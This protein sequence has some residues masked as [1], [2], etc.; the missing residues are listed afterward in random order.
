MRTAI[1]MSGTSPVS[2]RMRQRSDPAAVASVQD[3][4]VNACS[5]DYDALKD[6]SG[7][8][9]YDKYGYIKTKTA[10]VGIG[11][12]G[13]VYDYDIDAGMVYIE[14]DTSDKSLPKIIE[15]V[16]GQKW[17]YKRTRIET[18]YV[19]RDNGNTGMHVSQDYTLEE[20][21]PYY[22]HPEVLGN[23]RDANGYDR[24]NGFLEYYVYNIYE[25]EPIDVPVKKVWKY[26]NGSLAPGQDGVTIDVELGRY[27]LIEDTGNP[28]TGTVCITHSVTGWETYSGGSY[29]A[30]INLWQGNKQVRSFAYDP[31]NPSQTLSDV[32]QGVYT[33]EVLE[34]L[35]GY[36][37][38]KT[39]IDGIAGRK[40]VVSVETGK[41]TDVSIDTV[42]SYKE[43]PQKITL[44]VQVINKVPDGNGG[45]DYRKVGADRV[46]SFPAG[47]TVVFTLY[48]P[49]AKFS[50]FECFYNVNQDGKRRDI[51]V[52]ETDSGK[53]TYVE[54]DWEYTL[55]DSDMTI[56][57][58]HT[59]EESDFRLLSVALKNQSATTQQTEEAPS[60]E[61]DDAVF[62]PSVPAHSSYVT[63]TGDAPE[64]QIPGMKYVDD[65]AFQKFIRLGN[66]VWEDV[67]TELPVADENGYEYVY[68]IRNAREQG[69]DVTP[70]IEQ[71][72]SMGDTTLRSRTRSPTRRRRS[73]CKSWT[74]TASP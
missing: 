49:S 65:A 26:E 24:Y 38:C 10:T 19:W 12:T 30:T 51:P 16:N 29:G 68:Y 39:S 22:S 1:V 23:Y 34:N 43:P 11:G 25:R 36:N 28:A 15:D 32:P 8:Y 4:D 56:K 37:G 20:Q 57:L 17:Y 31:G 18:E 40:K 50:D 74:T 54:Q 14:E 61:G 35:N 9:D 62:T 53:W 72:V 73:P 21:Q 2:R 66:G 7:S 60:E 55:G 70:V 47:E 3:M 69:I 13:S 71:M 59:M 67:F 5:H 64:T 52:P 44:T 42:L 6:G 27:H 48:R 63:V 45:N 41:T 33:L 58:F 46:Y